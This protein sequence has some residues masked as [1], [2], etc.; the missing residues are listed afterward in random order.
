MDYT[1]VLMIRA[2]ILISLLNFTVTHFCWLSFLASRRLNSI[3][4][5]A[6]SQSYSLKCLM[7]IQHIHSYSL[8]QQLFPACNIYLSTSCF[9]KIILSLLV[10]FPSQLHIREPVHS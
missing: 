5:V 3:K 2:V 1:S 4:I 6:R 7:L 9:S 10:V 8:C